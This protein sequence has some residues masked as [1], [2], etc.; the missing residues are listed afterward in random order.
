VTEKHYK[1][2]FRVRCPT[3]GDVSNVFTEAEKS[4]E[5]RGPEPGDLLIC[6]ECNGLNVLTADM[7]ARAV[8][9]EDRADPQFQKD[10]PEIEKLLRESEPL[11]RKYRS[12]KKL[13]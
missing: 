3:C 1:S 12:G 11:V 13:S 2:G 7:K 9:V 10:W 4:T 8:T 5:N 6:V